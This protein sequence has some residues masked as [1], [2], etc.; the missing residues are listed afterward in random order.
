MLNH[1]AGEILEIAPPEGGE[2][3]LLAFTKAVAAEV[4]FERRRIVVIPPSEIEGEA[5]EER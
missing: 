1:G 3:L 2:T 4:D 5:D